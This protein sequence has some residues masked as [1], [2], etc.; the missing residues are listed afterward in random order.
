MAYSIYYKN[1]YIVILYNIMVK[2]VVIK[3]K[4]YTYTTQ[5]D[6]ARKLGITQQAAQVFK[7]HFTRTTLRVK[8]IGTDHNHLKGR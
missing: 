3:N 5:S 7:R 2:Q 8:R 4:K 1:K 6:L